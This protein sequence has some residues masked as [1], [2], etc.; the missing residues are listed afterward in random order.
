MSQADIKSSV[1]FPS[2]LFFF[3]SFL[4]LSLSCLVQGFKNL[5]I[6]ICR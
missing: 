6:S 2:S 5:I 4:G 3:M 1:R